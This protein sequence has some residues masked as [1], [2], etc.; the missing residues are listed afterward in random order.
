MSDISLARNE[1]V[2]VFLQ[3]GMQWLMWVDSDIVFQV[4]DWN[5]LWEGDEDIVTAEYARKI[6]GLKPAAY[7][8]GFTRV[9]RSVFVA[10]EDLHNEDT[11]TE[12]AQ[13]YYMGGAMKVNFHPCGASG[14]NRWL[15]EDRGFFTLA[16]MAGCTHRLET[17]TRLKHV[18]HIEFGYP[19]QM[20]VFDNGA[21]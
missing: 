10:I 18:G 17:R 1:I 9:H 8:L 4:D 19:N 12:T 2:H 21:N 13:R 6:P 5:L 16:A 11:V 7:G 15:G 3:T 14:D 20:E